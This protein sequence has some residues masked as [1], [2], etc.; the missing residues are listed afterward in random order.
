MFKRRGVEVFAPEL[1]KVFDSTEFQ[2]VLFRD[3]SLKS[4]HK[5]ILR[6]PARQ[7][8]DNGD[9]VIESEEESEDAEGGEDE[10]MEEGGEDEFDEM[11]EDGEEEV[12][13]GE[14]D[15][16]RGVDDGA[17]GNSEGDAGEDKPNPDAE[18]HKTDAP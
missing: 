1:D 16:A 3:S 8:A 10:M 9:V 18:E 2:T 6:E 15:D 17:D 11:A 12:D 13:E 7:I 14:G 4:G 5:L